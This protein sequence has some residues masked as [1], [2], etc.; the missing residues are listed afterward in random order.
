MNFGE[1]HGGDEEI[2]LELTPLIDMV[3]QLLVFFLLTTTFAINVKEGGIELDLP[4]A[5]STQIPAMAKHVVVAVLDDGRIVM[6]GE[7]VSKKDLRSE[8]ERIHQNSP[9]TLVVVQADRT[10]PHWRVVEVM[11]MA[12][13]LGLKRLAIAT[14]EE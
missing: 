1:R 5:K 14:V 9:Q 6:G 10:V 2:T 3:F 13:T 12:A 4:R 11:D 8:L 7:S